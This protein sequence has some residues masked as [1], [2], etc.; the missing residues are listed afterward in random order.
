VRITYRDLL[1]GVLMGLLNWW[2]TVFLMKA[3]SQY[4]SLVFFPIFNASIV[5]I[6]ALNGVLF[7]K[8]RLRWINWLGIGLAVIAIILIASQPK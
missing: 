2:S 7:F 5:T 3:L 4:D 1:A 8:E 6:A